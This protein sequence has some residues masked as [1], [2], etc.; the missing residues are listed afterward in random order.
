MFNNIILIYFENTK[1]KY[2]QL[3]RNFNLD[4]SYKNTIKQVLKNN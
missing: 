4:K 3:K 1:F 2:Q